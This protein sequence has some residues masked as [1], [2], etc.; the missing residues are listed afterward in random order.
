[1][2][3]NAQAGWPL[4]REQTQITRWII[5]HRGLVLALAGVLLLA[6]GMRLLTF[7][8]FLPFLDYA[9]ENNMYLMGRDWRGVEEVPV[10]PEWLAGYP[11]LYIWINIGIQHLV[12]AFWTGP[13]LLISDYF[14][15]LRL[16]GALLGI[17]TTGVVIALGCQLAGPA[18]GV[19]S[20]LMWGF[21]P[22]IVKYNSLAIPDPLVYLLC[23]SSLLL[24]VRA[25]KTE[26]PRWLLGGLVLALAAV[27][28]KYPA[29]YI[30]VPWGLL[31]LALIRQL[32]LRRMLPWLGVYGL[33]GLAAVAFLAFGYG[34][35]VL[36]NREADSVRSS[37]LS[38][39]LS[40]E[41]N[42][43]N[44]YFAIYTPGGVFFLLALIGGAAAWVYNRRR[45]E[46]VLD[47][48]HVALFLI[49]AFAGVMV[50]SSY[51]NVWLG[52]GKL[53]HVLPITTALIPI[54]AAGVMQ[55]AWALE[56]LAR[57]LRPLVTL[58]L[59]F[60]GVLFV[61]Y[62]PLNIE[63][64]QLYQRVAV[65][66]LLWRWTDVNMPTDALILSHPRSFV[67][68]TW[69]RPWTGYDG[70]KAFEWWLEDPTDIIA[71]TPEQYAERGIG[72]FVANTSDLETVYGSPQ[73]QDFVRQL[74]LVKT[75]HSTPDVEGDT[76]YFYKMLPPQFAADARF[77]EQLHLTGYDLDR[78]TLAPGET[79][80]FRAYWRALRLPDSNYSMFV[81]L[82]AAGDDAL[83]AQA[84]S[85]PGAVDRPTLTWNDLDELYFGPD[86]QVTI[87]ADLPAGAY[88]LRVG[89][90]DYLSGARL[91][92]PDNSDSVTI[93]L[94]VS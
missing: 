63:N 35:L 19:L 27:Y 93:T 55:I 47:W 69:N 62:L 86:V 65:Q 94:D 39:M 61:S 34:G 5:A 44:W 81:H 8:R 85:S 75:I 3:S 78:T 53:R 11:P 80:T 66:T 10:V 72:Y 22:L 31:T 37:G 79:L 40:L 91:L 58:P 54:M 56:P 52:A 26:S 88:T 18:A 20:G 23:S 46:R 9:D 12:E 49:Y 43:N 32:G 36:S 25:W 89:L 15:Y 51:S 74:V 45:G 60:A 71:S 14:Y 29:L 87:P 38:D 28:A 90:Y 50:T 1:M 57:R 24:S 41:R 2:Q 48:R 67:A 30:L 21:A 82:V 83:L 13:W 68:Y 84:D 77:G 16:F 42:L 76:A 70:Y 92:L 7:D 33:V 4:K 64:I 17:L 59:L 73:G 6:V